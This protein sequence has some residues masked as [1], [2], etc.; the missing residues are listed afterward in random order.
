MRLRELLA[1]MAADR[2]ILVAT[3]VVSDVETVATE[4]ILLRAGQIVDAAP[5]PDLIAKYAPRPGA[6][7]RVPRGIRGGGRKMSLLTRRTAQGLGQPGVPDAAGRACGRPTFY[8]SGWAPAPPPTSPP[9]W[10]TAPWGL[11]WLPGVR[12]WRPRATFFMESSTKPNRCCGSKTTT[13]T[14]PTATA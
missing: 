12:T 13:V 14:S 5:V 10:P 2:I 9:P 6:R 4:V 1:H 7:G 3:H 8:Y 11:I